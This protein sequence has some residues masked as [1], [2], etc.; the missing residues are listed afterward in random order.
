M[1]SKT[2]TSTP[3]PV[4]LKRLWGF[5]QL[6]VLKVFLENFKQ[7]CFEATFRLR[8]LNLGGLIGCFSTVR[9]AR[10]IIKGS[11]SLFTK[12]EVQI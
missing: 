3:E 1:T 11:I 10:L 7:S 5:S 8:W 12:E 9:A 6:C 2:H 4:F